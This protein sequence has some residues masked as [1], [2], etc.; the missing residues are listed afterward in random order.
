MMTALKYSS[1]NHINV[2]EF[3]ENKEVEMSICEL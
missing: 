2:A 1:A 3:E